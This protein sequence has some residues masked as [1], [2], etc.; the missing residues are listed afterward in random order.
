MVNVDH[1]Q[2]HYAAALP[3]SVVR[4]D[5]HRE[6]AGKVHV[7]L[8]RITGGVSLCLGAF[9]LPASLAVAQNL[10]GSGS[11]WGGSWQFQSS[12]GLS[13]DVQRADMIARAEGGFFNSFGPAQTINN[14]TTINDNR[15]NYVEAASTEGGIV[16]VSNRIGDDIGKVSNVTGS[17]NTGSTTITVDGSANSVTA[18][19]SSDSQGCLDGS[20]NETSVRHHPMDPSSSA[21]VLNAAAGF[22][23]PVSIATSSV[24][25][26]T[27]SGCVTR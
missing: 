1:K 9:L 4:M 21:S 5:K 23:I 6:F 20:I 24:T 3:S 11:T 10:N 27:Q 19:N 16:E 7:E 22:T 25:G 18:I 12:T 15:S 17:I 2:A 13:V 26:G 14:N 8:L